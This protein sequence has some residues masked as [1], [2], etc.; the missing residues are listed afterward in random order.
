MNFSVKLFSPLNKKGKTIKSSKKSKSDSERDEDSDSSCSVDSKNHSESEEDSCTTHS[1]TLSSNGEATRTHQAEHQI[2]NSEESIN[3]DREIHK[4]VKKHIDKCMNNEE[5]SDFSIQSPV[6]RS[7][8]S[9]KNSH[10]PKTV[11][12]KLKFG[13]SKKGFDDNK[14]SSESELERPEHILHSV[15][16][17]PVGSQV[18]HGIREQHLNLRY[19]TPEGF[20]PSKLTVSKSDVCQEDLNGKELWLIRAPVDFDI[21]Q[22]DGS[23]I[24]LKGHVDFHTIQNDYYEVMGTRDKRHQLRSFTTILP[25]KEKSSF[26]VG[27]GFKGQ[28]HVMQS[29]EIPPLPP[30]KE[31]K[32]VVHNV[33]EDLKQRFEPFGSGSPRRHEKRHQHLKSGSQHKRKIKEE[34]DLTDEEQLVVKKKKKKHRKS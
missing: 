12:K 32:P 30:I 22:L 14:Y 11:T 9:M 16:K 20:E 8:S 21:K 5:M 7:E 10:L 13:S 24:D 31:L 25:S 4:L 27:P 15:S 28:I 6:K 29:L 33:P 26:V 2:S 34:K 23:D 18:K 17:V 1:E 3:I 19:K